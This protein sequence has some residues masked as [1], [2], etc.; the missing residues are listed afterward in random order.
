MHGVTRNSTIEDFKFAK[1]KDYEHSFPNN[2]L[3]HTFNY[4]VARPIE[5]LKLG[6]C[7]DPYI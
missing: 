3:Y 2:I 1:R 4:R 5:T 7:L 6:P